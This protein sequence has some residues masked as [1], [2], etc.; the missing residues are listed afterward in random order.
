MVAALQ[1]KKEKHQIVM[2]NYSKPYGEIDVISIDQRYLVFT[3]VKS[4]SPTAKLNPIT[5]IGKEKRKKIIKTANVFMLER[6]MWHLQPRFDVICII[7]DYSDNN[8]THIQNAFG[9]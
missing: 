4:R 3:E 1:L 6:K 8:V 9:R 7:S 5:S 2:M